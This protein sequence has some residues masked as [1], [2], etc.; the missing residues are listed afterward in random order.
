MDKGCSPGNAQIVAYGRGDVNARP[1][2]LG[3]DGGGVAKDVGPVFRG[4]GAAVFPLGKTGTLV[5][6]DLHPSALADGLPFSRVFTAEPRDDPRRLR[7]MFPF[8]NVIIRERHVKGVLPGD[9]CF[10]TEVHRAANGIRVVE[11][12]EVFPPCGIPRTFMVGYRIALRGFFPHPEDRGSNVEPP[13]IGAGALP[14]RP[15]KDAGR[16]PL[17]SLCCRGR[18]DDDPGQGVPLRWGDD[19]GPFG[20][21]GAV[22][23]GAC[24]AP[25]CLDVR[26]GDPCGDQNQQREQACGREGAPGGPL[27]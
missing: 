14:G 23:Q 22:R 27:P 17:S 15:G 5:V 19:G 6:N 26:P 10:R 2:V 3:V 12:A 11:A 1:F 24:G 16:R 7:L 9:E 18:L 8:G 20:P 4:K 21:S 13:G 25:P